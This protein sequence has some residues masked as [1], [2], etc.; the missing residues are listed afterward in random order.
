MQTADIESGISVLL[1][2]AP[3]AKDEFL[4]SLICDKSARVPESSS[5]L[6]YMLNDRA[7]NANSMGRR[8]AWYI[9]YELDRRSASMWLLV[10]LI[11]SI[12]G[13]ISAGLEGDTN[14]GLNVGTA[15]LA[16]S[17]AVQW[18]LIMWQG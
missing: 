7:S 1:H 3:F 9:Y 10:A 4:T 15:L 5:I 17:S 6:E 8:R 2:N 18:L 11:L 13:G 12:A 14:L 16:A